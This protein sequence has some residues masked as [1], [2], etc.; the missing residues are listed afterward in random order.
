[1]QENSVLVK[2]KVTEIEEQLHKLE[3][4]RGARYDT[5][6]RRLRRI[7]ALLEERH[8]LTDEKVQALVDLIVSKQR[9]ITNDFLKI[10]ET[11]ESGFTKGLW[12]SV[13]NSVSGAIST[14]TTSERP[15]GRLP[16]LPDIDDDIFAAGLQKLVADRPVFSEAVDAIKYE[17]FT[18]LKEKIRKLHDAPHRLGKTM[19]THM[20]KE[21]DE[22]YGKRL[23]DENSRAWNELKASVRSTLT[24]QRRHE[25]S[26][27][28]IDSISSLTVLQSSSYN[29]KGRPRAGLLWVHPQYYSVLFIMLGQT[30][31]G[32]IFVS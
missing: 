14:V 21:L 29:S 16:D 17:M 18:L 31:D 22:E 4:A 32:H 15:A 24:A 6:K 25:G 26:V 12:S 27:F 19:Q 8:D 1:M 7:S 30:E 28:I 3:T 5:L 9:N 10:I 2:S 20:E 13:V 23:K 11:S